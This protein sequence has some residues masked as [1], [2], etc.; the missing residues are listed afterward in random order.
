MP[1]PGDVRIKQQVLAR[2]GPELASKTW[3]R[4]ADGSPLVTADMRGDGTLILFHTTA[5]PD[6]ADLAYSGTFSQMLRRSIA[7][8][9]G[10]SVGDAEGL[11]PLS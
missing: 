7:A 5:G 11:T 3:A 2:P 6:W 8:G 1:I 9:R 10:E 4:L